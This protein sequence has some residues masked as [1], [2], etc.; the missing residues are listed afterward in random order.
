ML[1]LLA[2]LVSG[3]FFTILVWLDSHTWI[4]IRKKW[5]VEI[6]VRP[7]WF[8]TY[9]THTHT[10][11]HFMERNCLKLLT[12]VESF[13]FG[14]TFGGEDVYEPTMGVYFLEQRS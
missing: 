9:C 5:V 14:V 11:T 8:I 4:Y 3:F 12:V 6:F 7:I 1:M 2:S 13:L 10:Y